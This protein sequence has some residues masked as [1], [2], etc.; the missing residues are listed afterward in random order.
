MAS[1]ANKRQQCRRRF[2]ARRAAQGFTLI[3]VIVALTITGFLLGGLFALV[4][5]SKRLSYRAEDALAQ[6]LSQ[7]AAFNMALLDNDFAELEEILTTDSANYRVN[8]LD[9]LELPDRQ[10]Q[11]LS[12]TLQAIE[13]QSPAGDTEVIATR[14]VRLEVGASTL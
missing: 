13:L 5:G 7:R 6:S 3:E 2:R 1:S 12:F 4:A 10:V 9:D 11:P 14:W 8:A